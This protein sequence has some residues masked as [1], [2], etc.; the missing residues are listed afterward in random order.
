M[1]A[2]RQRPLLLA[3]VLAVL[4]SFALAVA[5]DS[6]H[7]THDGCAVEIHCVSCRWAYD[8]TSST[9]APVIP[10]L[11]LVPAG[12]VFVPATERPAAPARPL[13]GSRAPPLA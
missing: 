1:R 4:G 12:T 9:I 3:A 11:R 13:A 10:V 5:E 7:H 8:A 2:S 6:L